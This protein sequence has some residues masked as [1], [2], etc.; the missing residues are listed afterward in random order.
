MRISKVEQLQVCHPQ[1]Y[2][3]RVLSKLEPPFSGLEDEMNVNNHV[4]NL[5]Q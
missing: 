5:Q 3:R 1:N 4:E 2:K